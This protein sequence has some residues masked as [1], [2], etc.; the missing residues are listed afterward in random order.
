MK[1]FAILGE[2]QRVVVGGCIQKFPDWPPGA[3][4]TNSTSLCHYV[5]LRRYFVSQC[6]E[7]CRHNTLCCIST[8]VYCCKRIFR[9]RISPETFGYT[10]YV[11]LSLSLSLSQHKHIISS[12]YFQLTSVT[13]TR[14]C[15]GYGYLTFARHATRF[16]L[17][18]ICNLHCVIGQHVVWVI[19]N[20]S[21]EMFCKWRTCVVDDVWVL[22]V[23][24][25]AV[26]RGTCFHSFPDYNSKIHNFDYLCLF[27]FSHTVLFYGILYTLKHL[28]PPYSGQYHHQHLWNG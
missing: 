28:Q 25:S 22:S 27:Q 24:K 14:L 15:L 4:T 16:D 12:R 26:G 20:M 19:D 7:F 23:W 18:A 10:S 11:S 13:N 2:V 8:S 21:I 9:Y 1:Y 6:S 17:A 3:R 5:Q